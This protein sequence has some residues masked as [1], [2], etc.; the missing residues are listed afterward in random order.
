LKIGVPKLTVIVTVFNAIPY[1]R[2]SLESIFTQSFKDYE[3]ILVNDG[4]TDDSEKILR[5][6]LKKPNVRLLK[7][8]INEG[9]PISRNRALL[10]AKGE[11]IAI[12]DGD[13]ISLETRLQKE[14]EFLDAHRDI[15]F[16]GSYAYKINHSGKVM[17]TMTYPPTETSEAFRIIKN[18]KLNPI[19]DSSCMYRKK[20]VLS[21]GGYS[22]SPE[23]R[24]ALDLH[25]WCRL[26]CKGHKLSNIKEPLIK[27]RINPKGVTQTHNKKMLETTENIAASLKR[28]SFEDVVLMASF[29]DKECYTEILNNQNGEKNDS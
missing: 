9:I 24:T 12:H 1:L 26:L 11:Y 20:V 27:Y 10:V 2:D 7:N 19:I 18:Y 13:D 8:D 17:G 6:Y 29:F 15:D 23:V 21:N 14:V 3:V 28:S 25:L 22:M 4:S 5:G 16:I